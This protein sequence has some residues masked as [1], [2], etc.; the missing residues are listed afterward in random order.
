MPSTPP[1]IPTDDELYIKGE[2]GGGIGNSYGGGIG[3]G[4]N[5]LAT[6]GGFFGFGPGYAPGAFGGPGIFK[7]RTE[8]FLPLQ[9]GSVSPRQSAVGR[10]QPYS[11]LPARGQG[12]FPGRGRGGG[13]LF[14][15]GG[16]VQQQ[17][18]QGGGGGFG[19][20][21]LQQNFQDN[22]NGVNGP[23]FALY[24]QAGLAG[25]FDPL[26]SG[27]LLQAIRQNMMATAG[28]R[29]QAARNRALLDA[30]NDPSLQAAAGLQSQLG[31]SS[32]L[33]N[34]LQQAQLASR[35]QNM[36]LLQ[37]FGL[38]LLGGERSLNQSVD[39][40]RRMQD[41]QNANKPGWG[42]LL[43]GIVGQGVGTFLGRL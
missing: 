41:I 34:T 28:A 35:L 26:G 38:G 40:A 27:P 12:G 19:P 25:A 7:R 36:G 43:G 10:A 24:G 37:Q 14:G 8:A 29:Q 5:T 13:G 20:G 18:Q 30:G 3:G 39:Q 4:G 21:W 11:G 31:F 23:D 6:Q 32:D 15:G 1:E 2:G 33:S 42:D 16:G 22:A 9:Q 17:Q